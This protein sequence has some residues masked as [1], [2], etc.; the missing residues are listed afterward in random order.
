MRAKALAAALLG[1]PLTTAL[2]GL[3]ILSWPGRAEI[4][5]LPWLLMSFPLWIGLMS[6]A[7]AA[8]SGLRAWLWMGG[9]T[10][11]GYGLLYGLRAF[12]L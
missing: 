6:L 8:R 12:S 10:A 2:I 3:F 11:L 4:V 7:F 5:T 9:A 1:L